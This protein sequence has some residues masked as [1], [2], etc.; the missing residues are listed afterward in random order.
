MLFGVDVA[1][2]CG[3]HCKTIKWK[4]VEKNNWS[5]FTI[6]NELQHNTSKNR[7]LAA[8]LAFSV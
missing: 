1:L 5:F 4:N 7:L 3:L 6:V 8:T 2:V